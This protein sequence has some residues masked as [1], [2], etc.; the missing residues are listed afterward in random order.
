MLFFLNFLTTFATL[1]LVALSLGLIF[2]Q[3]KIINLAQGD[4]LIVGAY[5]MYALRDQPFI[6][7]VGAAIV[8]GI[9]LGFAVERTVIGRLYDR[10]LMPTLLATWGIGIVLRQTADALFS[11]TPRSV[12]APIAGTT[13]IIGTAYPTYRLV[14]DGVIFVVIAVT[15]VTLYRSSIGLRLRASIDDMEMTSL[16]GT[17]PR[18]M[19]TLTF[20]VGTVLTVLAGA[21]LAP[22]VGITPGLGLSYL[23]PA[24]F[25][26][27]LG[28]PGTIGGPLFGAALVALLIG[29]LNQL[30]T[31][32]VAESVLF[33]GLVLLIGIRPQGV[34]WTVPK[35]IPRR[36]RRLTP[37]A[38]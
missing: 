11:S 9:V 28:R 8:A 19:F 13:E 37:A 31:A 14:M 22:I 30:F 24:F 1:A 35:N 21:L 23:A 20:T 18:R 15:L 33:A 2:G 25:A 38:Q 29:V 34:T 5:T 27:L 3:L 10:G 26:V 6:V 32:T 4:L 16:L 36:P 17:A 7:G 12:D